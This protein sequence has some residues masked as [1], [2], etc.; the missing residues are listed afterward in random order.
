MDEDS[1][2]F[3]ENLRRIDELGPEKWKTPDKYTGA[4]TGANYEPYVD[5]TI[6]NWRNE[7]LTALTKRGQMPP[8]PKSMGVTADCAAGSS[9]DE[10]QFQSASGRCFHQGLEAHRHA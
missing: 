5:L 9:H 10:D 2:S 6:R 8:L 3:D 4:F 1:G 7:F